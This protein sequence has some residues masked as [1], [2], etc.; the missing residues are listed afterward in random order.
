MSVDVEISSRA[1]ILTP[2]RMTQKLQSY[3]TWIVRFHTAITYKNHNSA[4]FSY[5][6]ANCWHGPHQFAEKSTTHASLLCSTV[7]IKFWAVSVFTLLF[8][9]SSGRR[10]T[11]SGRVTGVQT[12]ALPISLN[13]FLTRCDS[14]AWLLWNWVVEL[15]PT[16]NPKIDPLAWAPTICWK[17]VVA[18]AFCMRSEERRV[19]K[20]CRSRWS[21]YHSK[22]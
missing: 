7:E 20:E 11:T 19:G 14:A 18:D 21:P 12:C 4:T 13:P 6:D 5:S 2:P 16:E 1:A 15:A 22:K 9:F 10:H 3:N 8:F 17:F